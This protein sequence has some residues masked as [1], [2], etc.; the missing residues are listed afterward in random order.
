MKYK[1]ENEF[2]AKRITIASTVLV[3][4]IKLQTNHNRFFKN[5]FSPLRHNKNIRK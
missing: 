5:Y 3:L 4:M 1:Y 2:Y